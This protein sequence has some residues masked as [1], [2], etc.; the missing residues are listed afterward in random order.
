MLA[1]SV[2][3]HKGM[4]SLYSVRQDA[5]RTG[6][7]KMGFTLGVRRLSARSF[8]EIGEDADYNG[9][10]YEALKVAD[11]GWDWIEANEKLFVLRRSEPS[12]I[13]DDDIPF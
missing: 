4:A 1:G 12:G 5:E 6:L 10:A 7:T 13:M 2:D 8:L 11:A 9:N 3:S